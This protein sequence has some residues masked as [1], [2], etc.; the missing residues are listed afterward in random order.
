MG[1]FEFIVLV[2]VLGLIAR[3]WYNRT[4]GLTNV[5]V[6]LVNKDGNEGREF[7]GEESLSENRV[8]VVKKMGIRKTERLDFKRV[9]PPIIRYV[10]SMKQMVYKVIEGDGETK[11]WGGVTSKWG[12]DS[13]E[14]TKAELTY[15]AQGKFRAALNALDAQALMS[16]KAQI[17]PIT[18]GL[19]GGI[20]VGILLGMLFPQVF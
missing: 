19:L 1:D 11:R 15:E 7:K 10:G 12:D 17:M 20:L 8:S 2:A 5:R 16:F 4:S 3:W 18:L 9:A 6:L 14:K 13:K